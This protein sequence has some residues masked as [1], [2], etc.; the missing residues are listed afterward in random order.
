MFPL[1][2]L[3]F[4]ADKLYDCSAEALPTVVVKPELPGVAV[5]DGEGGPPA[6][7]ERAMPLN[8]VLVAAV[9]KTVWVPEKVT[10]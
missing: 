7:G 1:T 3:R 2:G 4:A 9:T 5:M 10:L 8:A 6:S